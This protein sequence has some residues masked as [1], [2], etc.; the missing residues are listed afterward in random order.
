MKALTKWVN[1]PAPWFSRQPGQPDVI[2]SSRL[3]LAR[4]LDGHRFRRSLSTSERCSLS[5]SILDQASATINWE[6]NL[7]S[8]MDNLNQSERLFLVERHLASHELASGG[9]QS[10]ILARQDGLASIMVGEEDHIR[11]QTLRPGLDIET[12]QRDAEQLD[13]ALGDRLG[14][15]YHDRWGYLTSCPTN[16]GSGL[17]ASVMLHLPCVALSKEMPKVL[18]GLG[19]LNLTARGLNGEGSEA[20]GHYYQVSNQRTL[21]YSNDELINKLVLAV[22]YV[23]QYEQ[24]CRD[25]L[26]RHQRNQLEDRIGRAWGILTN[27]RSI[28]SQE[29]VEQL[30]WLRLG[31]IL[32]LFSQELHHTIGLLLITTQRA[33]LQLFD[34]IAL[35]S[36]E[37]DIIRASIVR[38]ALSPEHQTGF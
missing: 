34:P 27:A 17:R 35:H 10:G 14:W 22:E 24:E 30:S 26:A 36:T 9:S 6:P 29:T 20:T 18:S 8:S 19:K 25:A 33:H 23:V 16:L 1:Q 38:R 13:Q 7:A 21:G 28:G 2:I 5:E 12:C 32:G 15:A 37:R 31:T 3:R 4:N 11:I